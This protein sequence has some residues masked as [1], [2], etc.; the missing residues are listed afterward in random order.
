[1]EQVKLEDLDL[2]MNDNDC[3]GGVDKNEN[4]Y[5]LSLKTGDL[6]PVNKGEAF[7]IMWGGC[8]LEYAKEVQAKIK[9]KIAKNA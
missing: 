3:I 4:E 1:M 2:Y 9:A 7:D 8:P 5:V 6:K